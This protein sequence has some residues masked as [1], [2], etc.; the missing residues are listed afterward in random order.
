MYIVFGYKVELK[1]KNKY[2]CFLIKL[3]IYDI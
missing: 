3:W 2:G 1:F